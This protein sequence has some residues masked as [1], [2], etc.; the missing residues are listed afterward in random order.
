MAMMTGHSIQLYITDDICICTAVSKPASLDKAILL[1]ADK[2][3]LKDYFSRK[4]SGHYSF[5]PSFSLGT[6]KQILIGLILT[7][8]R[9]TTGYLYTAFLTPNSP[10]EFDSFTAGMACVAES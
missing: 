2:S 1:S 3:I 5:G 10:K 4:L 9:I 7:M 8:S 6:W